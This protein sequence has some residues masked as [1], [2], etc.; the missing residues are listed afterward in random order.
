LRLIAEMLRTPS[1]PEGEFAKLQ[2]E[3]IAALESARTD[4]ERVARRAVQRHG[5]PYPAGD[6]RYVPTV[7]EA[8]A[9]LR[10]ATVEDVRRFHRRFV[11]GTG[12][13]AVVGDFDPVAVRR[14]L[15]DSFGAWPKAA[16]FARVPDPWVKRTPAMVTIETPDK[17]NAALAGDLALPLADE[18][19]EFGATAVAAFML[20]E[21]STSRLNT[22]IRERDGL[23]YSVYAFVTWNSFEPNSALSLFGIFAPQNRGRFAAALDD[24]FNRAAREGFSEAEV[25]EAKSAIA[26]RRTLAR[27]Q[28]AN[29]AAAL[30]QQLYAGRTFAFAGRSD[31][32]IAAASAADVNAAFRKYF[33]PQKLVLVYAGDFAK[34]P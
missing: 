19:P 22:R 24:E 26:K 23:S 30:V 21:G 5:N 14:V 10:K 7:D 11:G 18:S 6:P 20:G 33:E 29:V 25:A 27:T 9:L 13:I 32:A 1:F 17:A 3:E 12:Q 8:V 2:R 15:E 28:D 4:P 16:P 34:A 31:A